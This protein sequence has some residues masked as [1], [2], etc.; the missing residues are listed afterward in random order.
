MRDTIIAGQCAVCKTVIA[1]D[2]FTGVSRV[3]KYLCLE[4]NDMRMNGGRPTTLIALEYPTG[5]LEDV[6]PYVFYKSYPASRRYV[7]ECDARKYWHD[8]GYEVAYCPEQ[9]RLDKWVTFLGL[10]GFDVTT[11]RQEPLDDYKGYERVILALFDY[12]PSDS[13]YAFTKRE[14]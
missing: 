7:L 4:C 8:K 11:T 3:P 10:L 2:Y 14:D 9:M 13:P 12:V 5:V 1:D 6:A